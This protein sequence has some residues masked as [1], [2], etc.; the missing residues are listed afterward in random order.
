MIYFTEP[1]LSWYKYNKKLFPWR[2]TSNPY[3][4]WISE[5]MLQQTQVLTVIP[6]YNQWILKFPTIKDVAKAHDNELF[7]CWEGLG[8][9]QRVQNFRTACIQI[10]EDY[11]GIIPSNSRN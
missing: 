3:K 6:F 9:Y 5:I 8:Y 4:I 10:L 2:K 1:L 7:K 11:D